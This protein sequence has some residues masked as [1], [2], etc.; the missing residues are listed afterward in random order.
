VGIVVVLACLGAACTSGGD[1]EGEG[2]SGTVSDGEDLV[3]GGEGVVEID[4]S[5]LV[6]GEEWDEATFEYLT[7]ATDQGLS[8]GSVPSLVAHLERAR[9]DPSFE[10]DGT[11]VTPA[12]CSWP[13]SPRTRSWRPWPR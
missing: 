11:Q 3:G 1:D 2:G 9:R 6:T 8:K 13:S 10:F 5:A 4:V 7:F 12:D